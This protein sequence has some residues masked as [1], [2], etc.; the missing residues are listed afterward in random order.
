MADPFCRVRPRKCHVPYQE[1][2]RACRTWTS[3]NVTRR[4][5]DAL[6]RCVHVCVPSVASVFIYLFCNNTIYFVFRIGTL[7]ASAQF[8]FE[9][10]C[11]LDNSAP[12][13]V[14]VCAR[15]CVCAGAGNEMVTHPGY[16]AS[17]VDESVCVSSSIACDEIE[18]DLHRS[19]PEHPAFQSDRGIS[20]LRRVL[21]AYA[22]HNPA[23]GY[24]Q[25]YTSTCTHNIPWSHT[26]LLLSEY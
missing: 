16:Y 18:R 22:N 2:P 8:K 24:C 9:V 12:V 11:W 10:F 3:R 4:T 20:A 15:A 14:S 19:L 6:L 5:V 7:F 17:L 26:L 1:N 25:V 13:C 23:I 21:T